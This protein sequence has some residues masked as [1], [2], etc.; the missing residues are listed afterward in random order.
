LNE[1]REIKSEMRKVSMIVESRLLEQEEPTRKETEAIKRFEKKRKE[2][3]IK[4]TPLKEI[5]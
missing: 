1:L 3:K 5:E 4:L 2:G